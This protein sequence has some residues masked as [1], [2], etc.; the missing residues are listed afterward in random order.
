[1]TFPD[2]DRPREIS[3]LVQIFYARIATDELL[4]PVFTQQADVDWREHHETLTAFWCQLELG[5][6]GFH[7]APTQ[8]HS[9]LSKEIPFRREQ[10]ARWVWLFHD[11]VDSGWEGPHA[12]SIKAKASM[13]ARVQ[14]KVV[15]NA[16]AWEED[17]LL[18]G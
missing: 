4:G 5:I 15:E 9:A 8:K 11:T 13:I 2:L 17:E 16:E 18:A 6:R 3:E 7:G 14:S 1:M 10:F 12:E